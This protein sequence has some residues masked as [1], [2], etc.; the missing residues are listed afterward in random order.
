M[1]TTIKRFLLGLANRILAYYHLT[2]CSHSA[3][4]IFTVPPDVS[5]IIPLARILC[6]RQDSI[7]SPGTSGE[8][9]RDRVY[10]QLLNTYPHLSPKSI[11]TAI[12]LARWGWN[13][14][15]TGGVGA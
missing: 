7:S 9:K 14:D 13:S 10:E 6:G 3:A 15:D 2:V 12:L 4:N 1:H 5:A 11:H 8:Y